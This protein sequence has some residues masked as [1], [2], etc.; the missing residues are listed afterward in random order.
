MSTENLL[1]VAGS[2]Q[3]ADLLYAVGMFVADPI[4][5]FRHQGRCHIVL[6]DFELDRGKSLAP[7][8][9]VLPLNRYRRKLH[10]QKVKADGLA[11][12]IQVLAKERRIRRFLVP[13]SF[14][15]GLARELRR[16]KVRLKIRPGPLF[17]PEREFKTPD[18]IKRISASLLMAEVG[19]A[20][21]MQ[22]L[23]NSKIGPD[24]K[25][26]YRGAP[27]TSER[28]RG[29]IDTALLQAGGLP[30]HTIVAGGR[31]ACDPHEVG[32]GPLRAGQPIVIDIFPRSQKTGYF[33]DITRTFVKGRASDAVRRLYQT[34]SQAQQ[35][36]ISEVRGGR[37][38]VEV[39][40]AVQKH[41]EAAG[42]RTRRRHGRWEGFFHGTGHGLGLELH[43][44]P[45]IN[46]TSDSQLRPG[47]VV[48]IEPGLYYPGMGGVRL[49]DVVLVTAQGVRNL[50]RCEKTLEL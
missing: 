7:H 26:V 31:Q 12:V 6:S 3:N 36:A 25:L 11:R 42:Y 28:L 50:T 13:E 29:I 1:I 23:K 32:S 40:R 38:A 18:E 30:N 2:E 16:L 8:C 49:E 44:L 15:L 45:R 27:L 24:R 41:F 4:I 46:A 19:M 21:G 33:G 20:E 47:Q 14:P 39:H 48:T 34:V 17:F 10:R 9:R 37:A 35:L 5:Y 43:E 22:A